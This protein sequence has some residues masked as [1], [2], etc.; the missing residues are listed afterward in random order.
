MNT[1]NWNIILAAILTFILF[2]ACN[3]EQTIDR[4]LSKETKNKIYKDIEE[5]QLAVSIQSVLDKES[6]NLSEGAFLKD[7]YQQHGYRAV[8]LEKFL[9]DEQ[10]KAFAERLNRAQEHGLDPDRF[11]AASYQQ[12]LEQVSSKDGITELETAYQQVARL[13]VATANALLKYAG[14]LQYGALDP[15]KVLQRYYIELEKADT[16]FRN[17][18]LAS[19]KIES[20]LDSIQPQSDAYKAMQQALKSASGDSAKTLMVNMERER[21]KK[22]DIDS[23]TMVYVNIPAF[24]LDFYRDGK[25]GKSMKVVVGTGRNNSNKAAFSD[26]GRV[27]DQPHSHETPVLASKIHSVQ[28]NP[29][30]NIPASIA[31]K[32]ILK[33]VQNDR[34]YLSNA[35]IDVI[36]DGTVIE[37]PENLD[38][39]A[40][41]PDNLPFRFR[42]RP[43]SDNA[44]GKIKFLFK[45][46]SAV[47]LH[48]TPAQAAFDRQVRASSH[49]CVRVA[50]PLELAEL[51][52]GQGDKFSEIKSDMESPQQESAKDIALK[53]Q[54]QVVLDYKTVE[55]KDGKLAFHPDVY[56]IDRV[57]YSYL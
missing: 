41:S 14:T 27:K 20:L 24:R 49:G 7:Y 6:G 4:I 51:L 47:Y 3:R 13:E 52:F 8:M 23:A 40:Y 57:L 44:L 28:V 5:E 39:S 35:G 2:T 34:F 17:Q 54:T 56:G 19:S 30:W 11:G 32:E 43:G 46:N 36:E 22:K 33:Y 55:F 48:D 31:G 9:A 21:W 12:L 25:N 42:Q 38:W 15:Q 10:L 16:S 29:V 45:N 37:D 18:I 1:K 26:K 53:P 50:E